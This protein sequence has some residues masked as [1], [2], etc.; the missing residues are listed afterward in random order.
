MKQAD[1]WKHM[2]ARFMARS[3][4]SKKNE[5]AKSATA[6]FKALFKKWGG[7]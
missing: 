7:K 4:K 2:R 6:A 5:V 3:P 1:K